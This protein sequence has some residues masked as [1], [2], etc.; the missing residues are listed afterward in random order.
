MDIKFLKKLMF[1]D[2]G[3]KLRKRLSL[4]GKPVELVGYKESLH[5]KSRKFRK[6]N[7]YLHECFKQYVEPSKD[8]YLALGT[9]YAPVIKHQVCIPDAETAGFLRILGSYSK[10]TYSL[11]NR[12]G[13]S[14]TLWPRI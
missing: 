4:L 14:L 2:D 9:I 7:H 8:L 11:F 5:L 3:R 6:S 10:C 1:N 13:V 12:D